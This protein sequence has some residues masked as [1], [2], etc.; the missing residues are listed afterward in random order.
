MVAHGRTLMKTQLLTASE[1]V[2]FKDG[3]QTEVHLKVQYRQRYLMHE[4]GSLTLLTDITSETMT[5]A[6]IVIHLIPHK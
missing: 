4:M 1:L 6:Q 3:E 5:L 2:V